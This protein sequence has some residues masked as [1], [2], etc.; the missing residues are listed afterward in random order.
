VK[1]IRLTGYQALLEGGADPEHGAPSALEA[2]V[3]FRQEDQWRMKFE[4][5]PGRGKAAS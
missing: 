2:I 3:L 1:E 5:A 4:N